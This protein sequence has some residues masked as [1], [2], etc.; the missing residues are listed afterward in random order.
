MRREV[1][2]EPVRRCHRRYLLTNKSRETGARRAIWA[3]ACGI[4]PHGAHV[5]T[6]K[7]RKAN[8]G[9]GRI[10]GWGRIARED[11]R[12]SEGRRRR[13]ARPTTR[14]D[15]E[16]RACPRRRRR[17][18][19]ERTRA[20]SPGPRAKLLTANSHFVRDSCPPRAVVAAS[21]SGVASRPVALF[22]RPLTRP[23]VRQERRS[24]APRQ[25]GVTTQIARL[26]H[27]AIIGSDRSGRSIGW[28]VAFDRR[29]DARGLSRT[30][31][32]PTPSLGVECAVAAVKIVAA[33]AGVR[34]T[35][36]LAFTSRC[37]GR[38]TAGGR[39]AASYY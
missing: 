31:P 7:F 3:T 23:F 17:A 16:S 18:R 39:R 11:R 25:R 27:A 22:A 6:R 26:C 10:A 5:Y 20:P 38:G 8:Q 33:H 1:V 4:R 15:E 32:R 14:A 9:K 29:A 2:V 12:R 28:S 21:A 35:C 24:V 36:L 30:R 13:A 37:L 19:E 34:S